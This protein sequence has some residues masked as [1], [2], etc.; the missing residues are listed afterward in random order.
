MSLAI[1]KSSLVSSRHWRAAV[2]VGLIA[3]VPWPIL[4]AQAQG[5]GSVAVT[6]KRVV[7]EGRRR[8]AE[9]TL[10]NRGT[11]DATYRIFFT[12]LRMSEDGRYEEVTEPE[13]GELFADG[14][15]RYSPRQVTI[16]GL[17]S[18]S[19]RLLVRKPRDLAPGEYRSHLVFR[20]LP[21]DDVGESIEPTD[22]AQGEIQ[23]RLIATYSISI[24]IIVRHGNLSANVGISGLE[25]DLAGKTGTEPTLSLRLNRSG[26][27]SVYGDLA[28]T[29]EAG[30]GVESEVGRILGIAV[31]TPNESRTLRLR[32]SPPEGIALRNGQLRVV[33]REREDAGGA[34]LAEAEL[35]LP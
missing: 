34:V 19:V 9:V 25:F 12:N 20:S 6:P 33:Y 27:R 10:V 1:L 15:I 22:L 2:G 29:F 3:L 16:P 32:L 23:V 30:D 31:F 21:P 5:V 11:S 7:L 28:V 17:G 35:A 8:T 13:A 14:M 4:S 18:Q 24:P 26:D